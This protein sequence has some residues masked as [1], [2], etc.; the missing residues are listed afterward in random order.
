MWI[1]FRQGHLLPPFPLT[2]P[3]AHAPKRPDNKGCFHL[4]VPS[5]LCVCL[6]LTFPQAVLAKSS[7]A[8]GIPTPKSFTV[9]KC[10]SFAHGSFA[11]GSSWY[12]TKGG[13]TYLCR[14][15]RSL[16]TVCTRQPGQMPSG[17]SGAKGSS[18]KLSPSQA[19]AFGMAGSLFN[20]KFTD[21][22]GD[23]NGPP[24]QQGQTKENQKN[25]P[26][27]KLL[28]NIDFWK[29][30]TGL[31]EEAAQEALSAQEQR[32]RE[33][34]AL[35]DKMG[36]GLT[37]GGRELEP[38]AIGQNRGLQPVPMQGYDTA[39]LDATDRFLCTSYFS[40]RALEEIRKG[41]NA[42]ASFFNDQADK[43]INGE[44]T[45]VQCV[46]CVQCRKPS[47]PATDQ[48]TADTGQQAGQQQVSAVMVDFNV[49]I[50]R[51]Q[52]IE[53]KIIKLRQQKKQIKNQLRRLDEK[54]AGLNA[55]ISKSENVKD[56]AQ[57][58]EILK[59]TLAAKPKLESQTAKL[60]ASERK[61]RGEAKTI[62]QHIDTNYRI[63]RQ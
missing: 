18:S 28:S 58:E 25:Y 56:K 1:G 4:I 36:G 14:C 60:E 53:I 8:K 61:L 9:Q 35:L 31:Q 23:D 38:M 21:L 33:G 22:I 3:P 29:F 50:K 5:I 48:Q 17:Y 37:S 26:K 2:S 55:R 16:G 46:Q 27:K 45:A 13:A 20:S 7:Q 6:A 41:N 42:A 43:V 44:L 10:V 62:A 49:K 30:W 11:V 34:E 63:I 47:L 51:L 15:D 32:A 59:Q 52:H 54:A 24:A 19:L 39:S 40:F 12:E 57:D